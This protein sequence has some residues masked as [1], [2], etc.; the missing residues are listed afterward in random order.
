MHY[1]MFILVISVFCV[2]LLRLASGI[3]T[4][5]LQQFYHGLISL[6]CNGPINTLLINVG[7]ICRNRH[8]VITAIL[9]ITIYL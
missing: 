2:W 1:V 9:P 6:I 7:V 5:E 4:Y 8:I 3:W